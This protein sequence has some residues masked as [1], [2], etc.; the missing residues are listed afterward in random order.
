MLCLFLAASASQAQVHDPRALEADPARARQSVAPVLDGLGDERI[1]V[2]TRDPKSQQFF[3]QGLRL[4]YGFNHSE[5]L[6]AFKEAARL[7]PENAMAYWGWALVLGP[8]LNLPMQDDVRSQA[9]GAI[10]TAVSLKDR[11][12]GKER[13]MIEA[14]ATRYSDDEQAVRRNLD[15]AYAEAMKALHEAYP[16]DD[17]IATLYAASLMNLSPWS[18]WQPDGSPGENTPD[19]LRALEAV[20][21]RDPEHTGAIHYYIHL[22]EA[23]HPQRAEHAAD[24]LGGIAP[25]AGH[26]VHMPAH[27]YMRL[28]RYQDSHEQNV[29]AVAADE[30]YI[31]SCRIQGVYPLRYYPHNIHFMVWSAMFEGRSA[32]ALELARTVASKIPD[33]VDERNWSAYELFRSQPY[34][35]MVRFGMWDEILAEPRPVERARYLTGIWHYARALAFLNGDDTARARREWAELEVIRESIAAAPGRRNDYPKLLTIAS[36]VAQGEMRAKEGRHAEALPH[37]E[38]AVRLQ[39]SLPYAEPPAWYFPVRHTLGAVL[40]EAGRPD[41]AEVV[42]WADL[43]QHPDNGFALFGLERSLTAQGKNEEAKAAAERFA[44]AWARADVK[45]TTS[46]F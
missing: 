34:T 44:R 33:H 31:T 39:E 21:Q 3:N 4:T 16:G 28:G 43:R 15:K 7:D 26:L 35:T 9:W 11:V 12:S 14:L 29:K 10:Q 38:R 45:L 17:N 5:A 24:V 20:M 37:L 13:A 25:K 1:E 2:T 22:V 36:E 18:Y 8:N 23:M 27:I 19:A 46:R 42:Y 6:R 30:G 32:E 40:I 41:E